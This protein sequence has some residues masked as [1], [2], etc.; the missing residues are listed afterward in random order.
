MANTIQVK[1]GANASLPTLNAGEF[2]F[3]TDTK[4]IYIGDGAANHELGTVSHHV[5]IA[6]SG[7]FTIPTGRSFIGGDEYSVEG[8][9]ILEIQGTGMMILVG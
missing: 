3:S 4:Q 2:G 6:S 7:D 9:D 5:P 8:T 1:R